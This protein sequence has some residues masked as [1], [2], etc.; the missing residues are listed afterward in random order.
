MA[1]GEFLWEYHYGKKIA[2]V[3]QL[4]KEG[5]GDNTLMTFLFGTKAAEIK[6]R[7]RPGHRRR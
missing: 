2:H 7:Y 1:D 3:L 4:P 6:K 5:I